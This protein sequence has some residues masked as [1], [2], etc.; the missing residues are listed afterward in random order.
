MLRVIGHPPA[1]YRLAI[2]G[3]LHGSDGQMVGAIVR[4]LAAALLNEAIELDVLDTC[5]APCVSASAAGTTVEWTG[6]HL[7]GSS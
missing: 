3:V 6:M 7:Y 1:A 4:V 2:F 5:G